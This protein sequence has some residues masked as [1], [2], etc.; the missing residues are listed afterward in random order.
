MHP[1]DERSKLPNV[2]V[3]DFIAE[4]RPIRVDQV[5]CFMNINQTNV[6]GF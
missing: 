1:I 5:I 4:A 2:L 3:E 6:K